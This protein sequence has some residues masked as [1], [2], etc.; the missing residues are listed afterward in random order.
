MGLGIIGAEDS[1]KANSAELIGQTPLPAVKLRRIN[2]AEGKTQ[3]FDDLMKQ[4]EE[5]EKTISEL[6]GNVQ[7]L[8][9]KL[10]DNK[11]KYGPDVAAWPKEAR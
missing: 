5:F 8:K 3:N 1:G 10:L 11:T 6:M 4:I 9:Q 7:R 2:M